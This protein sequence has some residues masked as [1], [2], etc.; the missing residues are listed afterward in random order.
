[1]FLAALAI[2]E[3]SL[4]KIPFLSQKSKYSVAAAHSELCWVIVTH[5]VN[6]VCHVEGLRVPYIGFHT[7][8]LF[9]GDCQL[10]HRDSLYC[11]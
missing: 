6:H 10:F 3:T 5:V 8:V 2:I 1:M 9:L 4:L 7:P 11:I